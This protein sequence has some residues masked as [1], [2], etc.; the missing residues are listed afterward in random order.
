MMPWPVSTSFL[1]A[2]NDMRTVVNCGGQRPD[3]S[4][5]ISAFSLVEPRGFEPL[6]SWLQNPGRLRHNVADP[7]LR[8]RQDW[9]RRQLIGCGRGRDCGQRLVQVT[10]RW[11]L[12]GHLDASPGRSGVQLTVQAIRLLK[13][14][15]VG[16]DYYRLCRGHSPVRVRGSRLTRTPL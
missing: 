5:T 15:P 14:S 11:G 2:V 3:C 13:V 7:A 9:P 6:T 4:L 8:A 10:A 16:F 12:P 1:G